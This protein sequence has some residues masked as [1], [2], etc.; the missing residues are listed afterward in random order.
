MIINA[1]D[2]FNG[3]EEISEW[4]KSQQADGIEQYN[5]VLVDKSYIL[6]SLVNVVCHDDEITEEQ[7]SNFRE[8]T[9][10]LKSD[11]LIDLIN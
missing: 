6:D 3:F 5:K 9:N 1:S 7:L 8:K 11:I 4:F 2:L 10:K